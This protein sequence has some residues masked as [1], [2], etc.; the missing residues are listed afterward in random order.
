M[1]LELYNAKQST[2]SQRV[3][4]AL[5]EKGLEYTE[6]RLD[7]FGGDQFSP[8]YLAINPNGVVPSLIH[9]GKV[10]IDSSVILEYIDEVFPQAPHYLPDD[11]VARAHM[12]SWMRFIDEVPTALIRIPSYNLGFLRHFKNMSDDEFQAFADSKPLR[13]DFFMKMG[14]T[15]FSKQDV[16]RAMA[17]LQRNI[18]RMQEALGDG[19]PWLMGEQFT[20]ADIMVMPTIVRM[21]DLKMN[22]MWADAP[23]V[24]AWLDRLRAR[25]AFAITYYHGSLLTEKYPGIL[26]E[27]AAEGLIA[28]NT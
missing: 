23:M 7:L 5:N 21:D 9:D 27:Q 13:R 11:P 14:R 1:A 4:L 25:P 17:G 19:R 26:K 12:R 10:I 2:C 20:L 28:A 6:H 15:G 24:P 3:R 22:A 8:D 16:D 18:D